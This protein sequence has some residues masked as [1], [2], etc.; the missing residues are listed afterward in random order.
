MLGTVAARADRRLRRLRSN[1]Y[2][3]IIAALPEYRRGGAVM[4]SR[5]ERYFVLSGLVAVV[6]VAVVA[7]LMPTKAAGDNR[8]GGSI[9]VYDTMGQERPASLLWTAVVDA[10]PD[11]SVPAAGTVHLRFWD[12]GEQH[13]WRVLA[14]ELPAGTPGDSSRLPFLRLLGVPVGPAGSSSDLQADL[15]LEYLDETRLPDQSARVKVQFSWS[16][17]G[18]GTAKVDGT[19][20]IK[21]KKILI[22]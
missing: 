9:I 11:S 12:T 16:I 10:G 14:A 8:K 18:V 13:A 22:N 15:A 21:G 6:L 7:A 4:A 3:G 20:T 1:C 19:I 2:K 5:L 17:E